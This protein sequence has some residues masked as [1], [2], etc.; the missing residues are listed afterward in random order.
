M[1][2]SARYS[3]SPRNYTHCCDLI[4]QYNA[5]RIYGHRI[6]GQIGYMVNILVVPTGV[7]QY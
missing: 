6:N 1:R 4:W 7:L 5:D 3:L 2:A